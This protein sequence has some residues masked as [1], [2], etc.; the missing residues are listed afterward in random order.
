MIETKNFGKIRSDLGVGPMSSE[1]IESVFRYS[2]FHRKELMLIASKNQIDYKGGYVNGWTTRQFSD[3]VSQLKKT[4]PQSEVKICRDHC[5]PGFNGIDDLKDTYET[6]KDDID[7]NFD[8]IHID[9]CHF[10]GTK[11]EQLQESKKAIE[12]ALNLNPNILLEIGTDENFG[13]NYGIA[14]LQEIEKEL[15]F[16]KSFCRPEFY[17]VQTGS[18]VKEINQAGNFNEKFV[19]QISEITRS[20]EVK[21]KEHNDDYLDKDSIALRKGIVGAMNIAPQLGVIQ[22][23]LVLGKCLVYGIDFGK[24][25][26]DSYNSGKWKKWL[27]KNTAE[28]KMLCSMIA[29]H[30]NFNTESYKKLIEEL[31]KREDIKEFLINSLMGVIQHYES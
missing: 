17:V 13:A 4:Y 9:F 3:Y 21:I 2:H 20:H 15:D 18:L 23:Q 30:Y 7:N 11:E 27:S 12:Y 10:K 16:F 8:L 26:E 19:S 25:L 5:G 1:T 6:I 31:E 14:N 28:N 22:T 24:Y 29:G